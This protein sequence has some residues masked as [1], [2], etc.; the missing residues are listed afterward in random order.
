MRYMYLLV[1]STLLMI[2]CKP[3]G[4]TNK[5]VFTTFDLNNVN[6]KLL[7]I[8]MEDGFPPPIASRVYVYPHI[9]NY[10]VLQ[11][12]YPDS[13]SDISHS[14]HELNG[15]P[16]FNADDVNAELAALLSYCKVAK[17][18]IFSEYFMTN[19]ADTIRS[20]A[21][22]RGLSQTIIEASDTY[23]DS[24]SNHIIDWLS[25]DKYVETRTMDRF[26]SVKEPDKW[27]ETPPDYM[28]ALEPNWPHIRTLVI[29][30]IDIYQPA[31]LPKY[32][33]DKNSDFYKMVYQVYDQSKKLD[34]TL[35]DIAWFWDDNPNTSMHAGHSMAMIHKISPPG[36]WLN[37]IHQVSEKE[38]YSL[39]KTSNAY[40]K[41]SIAMFDGIISCW[42]FK[43]KTNLV[44][45]I[46]YIQQNID[47]DWTTVIQTPPFPEYTSGHSVL[48]ACAA[49]VL[50]NLFGD[51]LEFRD[52]TTELFGMPA[53][54]FPSFQD[55]AWEVSMSRLYGGIHYFQ[56]IEQGN[57]QGK[58]IGNYVLDKLK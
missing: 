35:I 56:G 34:S 23:A 31:P 3:E 21:I 4:G 39:S 53:R 41:A 18:V 27:Q 29:D 13:L 54:T 52:N 11:K 8:A 44:R 58:F 50:T 30:S 24:I 47:V 15:V 57:I 36:H 16:D 14:L 6:R 32:S 25:K 17:K 9:A 26:T 1:F 12:F 46:T 37:I 49:T 43:Y 42:Y 28:A 2:G 48:S 33:T 45:P 19:L 5:V 20:Q 38:G 10:I 55:A 7:E 40:T 22:Q 51:N